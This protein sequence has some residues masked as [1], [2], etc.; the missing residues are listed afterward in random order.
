MQPVSPMSRSETASPD[1]LTLRNH[2]PV[3]S[4]IKHNSNIPLVISRAVKHSNHGC[5]ALQCILFPRNWASKD[6]GAVSTLVYFTH[7]SLV[8]DRAMTAKHCRDACLK[9]WRMGG[10]ARV[11][12]APELVRKDLGGAL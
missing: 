10:D 12:E 3:P 11:S 4:G 1:A 9:G 2:L 6:S 5:V 8:A 7:V